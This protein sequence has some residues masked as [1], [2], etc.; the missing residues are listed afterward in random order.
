MS[1]LLIFTAPSG[2]GKTT[3]VRHL[4][5]RFDNL[6]F[7]VSATTRSKR[8]GEEE[9]L[10]YYFLSVDQFKE[11]IRRREFVEWEEVYENQFYG[12]LKSEVERLW[13]AGK[14]IIF[15]IDVKGAL[16]I[17]RHFPREALTVYVQ[18]PSREV[19]IRRLQQRQTEDENSLKRRIK[20]ASQELMYA[21]QFDVVL[22]ND[23]L[24]TAQQEAEHIVRDFLDRAKTNS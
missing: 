14:H 24:T 4:L 17:K 13:Q 2:A 9:G 7:S 23:E 20:R 12:T 1:K 5:Q 15:D 11:K 8:P 18:P 16:S 21:D 22:V 6:A 10:D 19:L 3:I